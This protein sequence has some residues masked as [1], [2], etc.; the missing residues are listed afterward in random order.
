MEEKNKLKIKNGAKT[1]K[2]IVNQRVCY[3]TKI[4]ECN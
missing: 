2:K 1:N 4:F 3:A